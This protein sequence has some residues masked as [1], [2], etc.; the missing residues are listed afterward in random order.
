MRTAHKQ[1]IKPKGETAI[2]LNRNRISC[3]ALLRVGRRCIALTL[4]LLVAGFA[5]GA[6]TYTARAELKPSEGHV[7]TAPITISLDRMLTAAERDT[8]LTAFKSGDPTA[9]RKAFAAQA[10]LGFVEVGFVRVPIKFAF[11]RETGSG[12]MVTIVCNE[13]IKH[14]GGDIPNAK[15]KAGYD[16]AYVLLILKEDGTGD[17]EIAPATKLKYTEGG[18]LTTEDYGAQTIWL[19]NVVRK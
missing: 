12:K 3:R 17:G 5:L 19:K 4:P 14:I 7:L 6:E 2:Y 16:F 13:P 18:S 1:N 10:D 11:P 8:L 15:P 9:L